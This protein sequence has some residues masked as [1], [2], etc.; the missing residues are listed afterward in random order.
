MKK[1]LLS[2]L[3]VLLSA[4]LLVVSYKH[5]KAFQRARYESILKQHS[6]LLPSSLSKDKDEVS[7]DQPDMAAFQE[8]FMT[9][10]PA[11]GTVPRERLYQSYLKT[12]S[13]QMQKSTGSDITWTGYNTDMG[14]RTRAIMFDPND[15]THH[16][17]LA[18]GVTG[19]LWTNS[20]ITNANQSWVP[21]GDFWP[22]LA[23]RCITYDPNNPSI[24]YIGTGEAETAIIT[25][26]E[27][28]GLG[29]G[30][31]K[32]TDGGAHW[33]QLY[34]T[35]SFAYV[36][37]IVVRNEGGN[38]VI[39]AA[40]VSGLYH[41]THN[42]L[43]SNGLFRSTDGGTTWTQVLPNNA[44]TGDPYS[45]SDLELGADGRIFVGTMPDINGVGGAVLLYSDSGL[46]GSW[47][48]NTTYQ[49]QI[50]ADPNYNIPGRVVFGCSPSNANVVYALVASGLIST[51]NNFKY[52]YCFNI[53]RSS[54][55]GATWTE[56]NQP[57]DVNGQI[58]F[59]YLAW[60]ALDI[61]V[62]PN[63]PNT[64]FIGG[65]DV[66]KTTDGGTNWSRMSDWSLMY[67]GGG[68]QYVHADQH[69]MVFKPGSSSELLLG[70]DGG[71]FY[72]ATANSTV[73]FETRNLG[74]T[75]LQF[76][77]ADLK[78]QVGSNE[79]IGGLQDNGCLYYYMEP[80]TLNDMVSG[81]DG[82]Y[83][84][85]DKQDTYYSISSV[86]YNDYYVQVNGT[87]T[88][89]LNFGQ[90][91]IFVNPADYDYRHKVIYANACDFVNNNLDYYLQLS[92]VTGSGYTNFIKAGT[93]TQTYF[94]AVKWSTFSPA[95][96]ATLF[97]G[98]QSGRLFKLTN[99]ATTPVTTEITGAN[100]P[101]G[102]ISSVN[103]GKTEQDLLVTFSNYGV[104]SVFVS[105]DGG[106]TWTDCEGNLP[107]MPVRWGIFHPQNPRHVMLA[108]ETGVWT[109]DNVS[110]ST[111]VWTPVVTGMA[112]VRVDQLNIRTSDNMVVAATHG[113]GLFTTIWDIV[114]ATDNMQIQAFR[115][116]PN[117][118]TDVL[119]ISFGSGMQNILFRVFDQSGKPVLEKNNQGQSS[120]Q[121][122]IT[123]L[124][125]GT[126][127]LGVYENGKQLKTEKFVKW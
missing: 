88:S 26:R 19:G 8:Y 18:G 7:A 81:G 57:T 51:V 29:D 65:L 107:D 15:A 84:F 102:N 17:V 9:L 24:F 122:N 40:V 64:V 101:V 71:I 110:A 6:R 25:Y 72:T 76:Y 63:D 125:P 123:A 60:H 73:V 20:D 82:A 90:S 117:P 121:I 66:Q 92:D 111:V 55:K 106:T 11:T 70:S 127:Y 124:A 1:L 116:Y 37:K 32:S 86:Y 87:T 119:N 103:I 33:S 54:D 43:P 34:T 115:V 38:S 50:L 85:F 46:S 80:V 108:T 69:I 36:P 62:D 49:S 95:S 48:V 75:T 112:N 52:Y 105:F 23:I 3:L 96:G 61:A 47:N 53:L 109:C 2:S 56:V 118:A 113:R 89:N 4:S 21:V 99:A 83:C 68:P 79:L 74:Y 16:K 42:S 27:S 35:E 58:N 13:L 22:D 12:R 100:F 104:S 28:S 94:S 97:L 31:W 93:T 114:D 45:P 39:Y 30:I 44:A 91:G 14:G 98:T 78:N 126:Y 67:S 10:D 120:D 41:G 5:S 59:A 77:T